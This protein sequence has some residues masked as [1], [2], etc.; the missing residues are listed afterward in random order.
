MGPRDGLDALAKRTKSLHL[1]EIESR[2]ASHYTNGAT[3]AHS[4]KE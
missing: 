3:P 2:L 1:L 4:K